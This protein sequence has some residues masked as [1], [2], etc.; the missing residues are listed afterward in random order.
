MYVLWKIISLDQSKPESVTTFI[1]LAC[2]GIQR[3]KSGLMMLDNRYF[4]FSSHKESVWAVVCFHLSL[5][6]SPHLRAQNKTSGLR[7]F[8]F[9]GDL[10]FSSAFLTFIPFLTISC[11]L[12]KWRW[13]K[14]KKKKDCF[15]L[16]LISPSVLFGGR[17]WI[18]QG[19]R[20]TKSTGHMRDVLGGCK[21]LEA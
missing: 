10:S 3:A 8:S 21:F 14:K 16:L 7:G 20:R 4:L 6:S 9:L 2:S 15:R 5:F 11:T 19:L 13:G 1:Y 17:G 12:G 18:V